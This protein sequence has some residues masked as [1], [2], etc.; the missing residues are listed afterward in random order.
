[1]TTQEQ[2]LPGYGEQE[3]CT[4]CKK[5]RCVARTVAKTHM[6]TAYQ[7]WQAKAKV[8]MLQSHANR[9]QLRFLVSRV[10]IALQGCAPVH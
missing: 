10:S 8:S 1:M 3:V 2:Q 6:S 7:C 4:A 9:S 5:K